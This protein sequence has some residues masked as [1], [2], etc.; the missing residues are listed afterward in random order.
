MSVNL[1]KLK[2]LGDLLNRDADNKI[3]KPMDL[4][5]EL[6]NEDPNQPR[7]IFDEESLQELANSI[8]QSGI[9][10]PL[11][12]RLDNDKYVINH[13]A[14]RYR[15]A[16]MA[17]LKEIPVYLDDNYTFVEQIVEN[18]QRDDLKPK[19]IANAIQKLMN[20]NYKK[21]DIAKLLGKS[22]AFVTQH[23]TLLNLPDAL[24]KCVETGKLTDLTVINELKNLYEK[25][26]DE[27]KTFLD[28]GEDFTR[29]S[30][31][32]FKEFLKSG[33]ADSTDDNLN[34]DDDSE[35][36]S[37]DKSNDSKPE[38]KSNNSD[39]IKKPIVIVTYQGT[40]ARLILNKRGTTFDDEKMSFSDVWIKFEED[41]SIECVPCSDIKLVSILDGHSES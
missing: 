4:D 6:I 24:E 22:N 30:V 40:K 18:I 36:T 2:N 28:T 3:T 27:V 11:S 16:K 1:D 31:R 7:T 20:L 23:L 32:S 15:A 25:N 29:N 12:V 5:I 17:G 21:Q 33:N 13:G 8:K 39:K 41:G 34:T 9:K 26:P 19:E 38:S 35:L 10:T 37:S 14:R